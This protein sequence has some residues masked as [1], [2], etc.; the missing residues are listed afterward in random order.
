MPLLDNLNAIYV[1]ANIRGGDEFGE[2][3]HTS[4]VKDKRQNVFDD[5]I[6]AAEYLINNLM[7][8]VLNSG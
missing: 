5:F 8:K 3:W 4:G 7:H 1:V 6:A 2:Q